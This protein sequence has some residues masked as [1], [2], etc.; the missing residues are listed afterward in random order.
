MMSIRTTDV[1]PGN[2]P[3]VTL[4]ALALEF[5]F[6][7]LCV[8]SRWNCRPSGVSRRVGKVANLKEAGLLF[9]VVPR[10]SCRHLEV[11]AARGD[12]SSSD[13]VE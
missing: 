7:W 13:G 6:G 3:L 5:C 11:E 4:G 10:S 8:K 9:G 2:S 12:A 1:G